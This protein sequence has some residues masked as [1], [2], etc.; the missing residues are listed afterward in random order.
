MIDKEE[1]ELAKDDMKQ[2]SLASEEHN[3][4]MIEDEDYFCEWTVE[5]L[6]LRCNDIFLFD[7]FP[8]LEKWCNQWDNDVTTNDILEYMKRDV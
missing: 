8:Q 6:Q 1:I 5:N 3:K 2:E 7:V 4:R